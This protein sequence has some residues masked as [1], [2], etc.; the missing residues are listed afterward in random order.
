VKKGM[1]NGQPNLSATSHV[2]FGSAEEKRVCG[3]FSEKSQH[4]APGV[5]GRNVLAFSKSG[6]AGGE[7]MTGRRAY[8]VSRYMPGTEGA[9][10]GCSRQQP[11]RA[12]SIVAR[13]R[14]DEIKTTSGIVV[15]RMTAHSTKEK[16][17][18]ARP[19][20]SCGSS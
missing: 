3:S 12:S 13:E 6:P 19:A 2:A 10:A 8:T 5:V 1:P 9:A 18:C 4:A 7:S 16:P 11:G 20:P 14:V 17:V 15:D